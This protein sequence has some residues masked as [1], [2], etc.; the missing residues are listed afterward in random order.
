MTQSSEA[1]KLLKKAGKHGVMNYTFPQH[2]LL[3]YSQY[4]SDL[5]D[6]GYTILVERQYLPN[7]RATNVWKYTLLENK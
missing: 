6:E 4:I 7:G 2:R 1:L 5:R 3:R